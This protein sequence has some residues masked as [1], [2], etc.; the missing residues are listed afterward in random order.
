MK[1]V[2]TL[3]LF[4]LIL[5]FL[6]F[7]MVIFFV[8]LTKSALLFLK[9]FVTSFFH[10]SEPVK[11]IQKTVQQ[12]REKIRTELKTKTNELVNNLQAQE[13]AFQLQKKE[14]KKAISS[15]RKRGYYQATFVWFLILL[16]T[17]FFDDIKHAYLSWWINNQATQ[18]NQPKDY[19]LIVNTNPP[20]SVVKIMNIKRK[21]HSGIRLEPGKYIIQVEHFYY[22]NEYRCITIKNHNISINVQLKK[23]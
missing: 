16:L 18:N 9:F 23:W 15:E 17:I 11:D 4:N 13:K 22:F 10:Q 20:N 19:L 5:S 2:F 6:I 8:R 14:F 7:Q 12:K 3:L 1:L 21:Y